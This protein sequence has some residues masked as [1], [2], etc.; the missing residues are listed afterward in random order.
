METLFGAFDFTAALQSRG[1]DL[2]ALGAAYLLF[3]ASLLVTLVVFTAA[4]AYLVVAP[5]R[6]ARDYAVYVTAVLTTLLIA[7]VLENELLPSSTPTLQYV[8]FPQLALLIMLHLWIAYRQ[9]PWII[10]LGASAIAASA[11]V[12][13]VAGLTTNVVRIAHVVTLLVFVGLLGFLWLKAI[14]TKRGFM[15]ASSIYISARRKRSTRAS[16]RRNRGSAWL[17]GWR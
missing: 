4:R 8:A 10:E 9:E 1:V 12:V 14:S 2:A 3:L 16:R 15:R 7:T 13:A 11:A 17:S 5:N 6:H